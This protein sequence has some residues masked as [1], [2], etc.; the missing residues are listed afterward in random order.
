M[1]ATT[2]V[3]LGLMTALLAFAPVAM[4]SAGEPTTQAG[5]CQPVYVDSSGVAHVD[6]TCLPAS[7]ASHSP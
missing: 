5:D 6:P 2:L 1:E 3:A 7:D 4:A